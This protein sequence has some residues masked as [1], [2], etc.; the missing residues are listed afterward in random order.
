MEEDKT[1]LI[2]EEKDGTHSAVLKFANFETKEDAE[3]LVNSI[4]NDLGFINKGVIY[5]TYH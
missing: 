2:V 4:I 5:P 3:I 1:F